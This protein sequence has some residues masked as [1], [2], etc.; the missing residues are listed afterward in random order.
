[1][2]CRGMVYSHGDQRKRQRD[3]WLKFVRRE[4]ENLFRERLLW[5]DET[6]IELFDHNYRNH[7]GRKDG[8]AYSPKNTVP[9]VKFGGSS[10]MIW[11]CFSV[12]GVGKI[13]IIKGK[14]NAQKYKQILQRNLKSSVEIIELPSDY[15]FQQDNNAKHTA[16][17][18]KKWLS[19]NNVLQ[20]PS[21]SLDLN[22]NSIGNL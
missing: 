17:S 22:L 19:G 11:E 21:Q 18:T 7:V 14:M 4:K 16:K 12:K 15:I 9:T 5:T 20:W 10:I 8:E 3:A 6:K 13:S 1:M 2:K